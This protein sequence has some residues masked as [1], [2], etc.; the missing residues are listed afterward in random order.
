MAQATYISASELAELI[1]DRWLKQWGSDDGTPLVAIDLT[2]AI[3][4]AVERASADVESHALRGGRYTA[5]HLLELQTADD[6]T[7][8]GLVADLAVV[9]L[10]KSRMGR[11]LP[12]DIAELKTKCEKTL[13]DLRD[14]LRV[15]N[16]A[17]AI[18]GGKA[19]ISIIDAGDR[20][21][22]R[23]P[24]DEPFFRPRRTTVV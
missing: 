4:N 7:L 21:Q 16:L 24:S 19:K 14:G 10:A 17:E 2:G 3:G 1:D 8:K 5:T 15:F 11:G 23:M 6:W 18:E 13:Q 12:D 9:H 22:L 20:T